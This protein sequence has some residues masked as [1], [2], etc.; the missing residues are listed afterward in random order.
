[1][2]KFHH[3][4]DL[5]EKTD[6][7]HETKWNQVLLLFSVNDLCI[8]PETQKQNLNKQQTLKLSKL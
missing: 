8:I 7:T 1:M 4:L 2:D 6:D 3:W 5:A